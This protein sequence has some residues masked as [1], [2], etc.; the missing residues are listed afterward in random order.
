MLRCPS[1]EREQVVKNGMARNGTQTD[2]CHSCGRRFHPE[3]KPVAHDEATRTQMLDALHQR[4]VLAVSSVS[5]AYIRIRYPLDQ[6][7]AAAIQ[8][9]PE[10]AENAWPPADE[11]VVDLDER[12]TLVS[13]NRQAGWRWIALERSTRRVLAWVV[14]DRSQRWLLDCGIVDRSRPSAARNARDRS[15]RAQPMQSSHLHPPRVDEQFAVRP[16]RL[17]LP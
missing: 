5:S 17:Q 9:L 3:A 11:L 13:L 16:P 1:C 12:W 10:N 14:G 7:Q 15:E 2:L 6:T 4:M 8:A